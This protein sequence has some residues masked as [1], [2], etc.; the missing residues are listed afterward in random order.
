MME[1][2]MM[3]TK[4]VDEI[5]PSVIESSLMESVGDAEG[6]RK[7]LFSSLAGG[8][9]KTFFTTFT[10]FTTALINGTTVVSSR[11]VVS[12]NAVT[13]TVQLTDITKNFGSRS[14]PRMN[15]EARNLLWRPFR[16]P[17]PSPFWS[18]PLRL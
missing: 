5:Q 18:P 6:K 16:L 8:I 10:F 1:P 9:V 15:A 2:E 3:S 14:K 12:T 7:Q 13:P 4:L 17:F 11:I